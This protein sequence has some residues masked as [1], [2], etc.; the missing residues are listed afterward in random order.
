MREWEEKFRLLRMA[1]KGKKRKKKKTRYNKKKK[2]NS[3]VEMCQ[4]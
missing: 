4:L 1:E 3:R 2:K